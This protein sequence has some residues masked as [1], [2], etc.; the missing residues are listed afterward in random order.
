MIRRTDG[1]AEVIAYVIKNPVRVGLV[2][3]PADYPY[4]GSGDYSRHELLQF[5][6]Y[7]GV[8]IA[9]SED[10]A[11]TDTR[12]RTARVPVTLHVLV[13]PSLA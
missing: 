6:G 1:L 5:V 13:G 3:D 7:R 4:W 8:L 12:T 11:Y 10:P 9:G 2:S